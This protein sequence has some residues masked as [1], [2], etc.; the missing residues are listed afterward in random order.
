VYTK[1]DDSIGEDRDDGQDLDGGGDHGGFR[2]L[3]LLEN[4]AWLE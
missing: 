2:S 3:A 1:L 4:L